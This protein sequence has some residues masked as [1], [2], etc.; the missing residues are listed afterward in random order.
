MSGESGKVSQ[1]FTVLKNATSFSGPYANAREISYDQFAHFATT[2]P[3]YGFFYLKKLFFY[4]IVR[5]WRGQYTKWLLTLFHMN[6]ILLI[7][8]EC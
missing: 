1:S 8:T 2:D 6:D 5:Q 3:K 7:N 4:Y